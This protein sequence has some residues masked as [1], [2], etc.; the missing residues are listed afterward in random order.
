[1]S[2]CPNCHMFQTAGLSFY[3]NCQHCGWS[4]QNLQRETPPKQELILQNLIAQ[5]DRRIAELEAEVAL[6]KKPFVWKGE[7]L[8]ELTEEVIRNRSIIDF[9]EGELKVQT[10]VDFEEGNG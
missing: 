1:M 2:A 9:E 4:L 5:K 3:G 10:L 7:D 8:E 6:L